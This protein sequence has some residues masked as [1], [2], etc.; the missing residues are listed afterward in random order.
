MVSVSA[1]WMNGS[2]DVRHILMNPPDITAAVC[3]HVFECTSEFRDTLH[4]V[5]RRLCLAVDIEEQTVRVLGRNSWEQLQCATDTHSRMSNVDDYD[6]SG[7][8]R[9]PTDG[10]SCSKYDPASAN[11][12][13]S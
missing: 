11:S 3:I 6:K 4:Y 12:P 9:P 2:S 8:K 5:Q 10:G 13:N 1:T 7:R